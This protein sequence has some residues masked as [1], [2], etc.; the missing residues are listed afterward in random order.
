MRSPT[1]GTKIRSGCL[2][3]AFL[4]AQT[5]AEMLCHPYILGDP[6]KKGGE[7]QKWVPHPCLLVWSNVQRST[8]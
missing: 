5:R 1:K 7:I 2:T 6:Q 4:G 3:L 8:P